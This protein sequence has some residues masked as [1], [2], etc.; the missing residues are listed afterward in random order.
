MGSVI[1]RPVAGDDVRK[2]LKDLKEQVDALREAFSR[3]LEPYEELA[4]YVERL[5][6]MSKGYFRLLELVQRYGAV[7][8]DLVVP[9][10]K[11]DIARHIVAA[12]VESPDRN[13]SEITEAVKARRGTAS[14][15]IV[16]ERLEDLARQGV[17]VA[18]A[19][20]RARTFR[21]SEEL[22]RKWSRILMP[23]E[24]DRERTPP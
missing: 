18:A 24:L 22:A 20:P 12:L 7:S 17:V 15:R 9:G 16:R 10:L 2:D 6:E 13:I 5:Q 21:V 14:R 11:D 19:G 3:A 23:G 8:P 1:L 4:R